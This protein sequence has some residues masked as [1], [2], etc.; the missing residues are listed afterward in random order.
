MSVRVCDIAK[1]IEQYAPLHYKEEWDNVGLLVGDKNQEV[2][3]VLVSLNYSE[4]VIEE[5]ISKNVDM[6]VSHHP[7]IY[8]PLS[9]ITLDDPTG[10]KIIDCIK[11]DIAVYAMHTNFDNSICGTNDILFDKLSLN[12]KSTIDII[13]KETNAGGGRIG[14]L[15]ERLTFKQFLDYVSLK[16]NTKNIVYAEDKQGLNK[17]IK[18]VGLCAGAAEIKMIIKAKSMGCDV[19]VTGDI[20]LH[21]GQLAEEYGIDIV[22]I[23]HYLSEKIALDFI[24]KDLGQHFDIQVSVTEMDIDF[25]RKYGESYEY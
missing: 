22:D 17:P 7:M 1:H 10:K 20:G 14:D 15:S 4:R 18:K 2:K 11:N 5:A 24:K 21:K 6:L 16:L 9:R 12:N 13:D 8:K 23:G 25:L 19:F 3:S